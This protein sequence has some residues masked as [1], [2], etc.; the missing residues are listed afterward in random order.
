[1]PNAPAKRVSTEEAEELAEQD[2]RQQDTERGRREAKVAAREEHLDDIDD[3]LADIDA[4]LE[5]QAVLVNYR[6]KGGQMS[7]TDRVIDAVIAGTMV[8]WNM[9]KGLITIRLSI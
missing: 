8:R 7:I 9:V 3:L 1:M 4:I 2:A 5:D 6:Q